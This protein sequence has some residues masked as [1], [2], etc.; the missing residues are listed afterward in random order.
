MPSESPEVKPHTPTQLGA[1]LKRLRPWL[2]TGFLAI[3]LAPVGRWLH[4]IPSCVF[5]CYS[6]PLSSFACPIGVA[7]NYAALLPV[8]FEIPYLLLGVLLLVAALSGSLACG[9]ACP[10]GFVQ[11]LLGKVTN[12]KVVLPG[13]LGYFRFVVLV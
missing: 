2:Q 4:G 8:A 5:H 3:W 7:A 13:W 11:D 6:C 10:F 9:W 1:K 12:T